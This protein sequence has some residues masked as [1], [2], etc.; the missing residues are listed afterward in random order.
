MNIVAHL[1]RTALGSIIQFDNQAYFSLANAQRRSSNNS[2]RQ[3]SQGMTHIREMSDR[4]HLTRAI[5]VSLI[6][7]NLVLICL[8]IRLYVCEQAFEFK[9]F[10]TNDYQLKL[11]N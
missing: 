7:V 8:E 6:A 11:S 3:M 5:Q 4:I 10:E 9:V 2:D 1:P